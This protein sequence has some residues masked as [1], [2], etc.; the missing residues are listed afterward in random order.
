[1][2]SHL[3]VAEKVEPQSFASMTVSEVARRANEGAKVHSTLPVFVPKRMHEFVAEFATL[4][5]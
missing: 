4:A 5:L 3:A 1:M 2:A